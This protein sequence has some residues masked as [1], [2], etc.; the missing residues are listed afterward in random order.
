MSNYEGK[1]ELYLFITSPTALDYSVN[2]PYHGVAQTGSLQPNKLVTI[3]INGSLKMTTG[4]TN[5]GILVT[6]SED[7]TVYGLNQEKHT[8]DMPSSVCPRTSKGTST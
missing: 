5:N 8:T 6:S 1:A 3:H 4:I 2:A 7:M